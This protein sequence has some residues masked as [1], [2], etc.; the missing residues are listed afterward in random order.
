MG[1][2]KDEDVLLYAERRSKAD[3]TL[4][5]IRKHYISPE[6]Y[7]LSECDSRIHTRLEFVYNKYMAGFL[8]DEVKKLL[9]DAFGISNVQAIN[10]VEGALFLFG[11]I[12]KAKKN[13]S[14]HFVTES[15]RELYRM[16]M[17]KHDYKSALKALEI[18]TKTEGLDKTDEDG[19][20]QDKLKPVEVQMSFDPI[21][22]EMM[23]QMIGQGVVNL[24]DFMDN[25]AEQVEFEEVKEEDSDE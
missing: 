10:D 25:K 12:H 17:G 23:R 5:R 21:A 1:R 8:K 3:S 20:L 24:N 6:K 15:A 22:L 7:P 9:M 16:S 2:R 11:D 13:M 18:I 19:D 4:D 14:R